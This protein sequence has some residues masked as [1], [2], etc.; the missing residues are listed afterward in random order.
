MTHLLDTN[1]CS[2]YLRRPGRLAHRFVQLGGG[3][4][5]PTVVLAELYTWA[6]RRPD[7]QRLLNIIDN[8]LLTDVAVLDFDSKCARLFGELRAKMLSQGLVTSPID[9]MIGTVALWHNLTLVTNNARH[10]TAIPGLRVEDW[11]N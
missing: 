4:A 8:D 6:Y 7:P 1:I 2:A 5:I 11:I 10:F 3:L 9:L